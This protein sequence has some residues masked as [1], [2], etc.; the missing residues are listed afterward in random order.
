M[1]YFGTGTLNYRSAQNLVDSL[2]RSRA[3]LANGAQSQV[4][5]KEIF[6]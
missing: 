1:V 3:D 5:I 4:Q 6:L 2:S